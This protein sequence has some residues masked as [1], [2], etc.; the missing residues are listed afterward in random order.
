[1]ELPKGWINCCLIDA[2]EIIAGQSPESKYYNES[3][4]GL[5]FFQGKADFGQLYP[6][7][8]VYCTAPKKQ[9][10]CGDIL[11]SVR[12]PVGP[13]NLAR[14]TVAIGRG[15]NAI[16][17][18][19]NILTR[20]VLYY[21][22]Q[23]EPVFSGKGTGTT[24]SAVT[25]DDVK[26]LDFPLPPLAEQQRIVE[27]IDALFSK[28]DKGA[29]TLKTVRQQ[30]RTYRQAVL[31]WAFEGKLPGIK[32]ISFKN[33]NITEF[34]EISGGITK[35][36]TRNKL[37]LKMP[38]LRVA[39][40]YYNYLNLTEVKIIGVTESEIERTVLLP[41][42]LLFVE[43]NGS[44]E[45]IGRVA[46]WGGEIDK[47][48][49]QNHIVKGRPNGSMMAKYAIYYLMSK[50]GRDQILTIASSTSGLYTLSVNKI[51]SLMLPYCLEQQKLVN[52][53]ESRLSVC[54][55][56]EA[57]VEESLAKSEALRQSILKKAF[58]G[59]LVPQD[60]KD[61]PAEKLLK[62]IMTERQMVTTK[63]NPAPKLA[64]GRRSK[65]QPN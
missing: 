14:E 52:T 9:A 2:T 51:K 58:A 48:L 46:M 37:P 31:K 18:L 5:P 61:E 27:K 45:Q 1:M 7:N 22:K 59:R 63:P 6:T 26:N 42:D 3:G 28:L 15:L 8:R 56:L 19:G 35:N 20:Y 39:N 29:E 16:R 47:C 32:D 64:R 57:I 17:P 55:K 23:I 60:P 21:F 12:A 4:N 53:I 43:G 36:S 10:R 40:V 62:R 24:F 34:F 50:S 33:R 30:L 13:T 65:G 25:V 49:H 41:N 11:L 44:K 38:Y 54:D